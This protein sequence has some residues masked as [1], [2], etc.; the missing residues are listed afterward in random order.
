MISAVT[1]PTAIPF[2]TYNG[3][4]VSNQFEPDK[5]ESFV[6]LQDQK[7]FDDVFGEAAADEDAKAAMLPHRLPADVFGSK[8]V[9]AAIKRAGAA[10]EFKVSDVSVDGGVLIVRYTTSTSAKQR[11]GSFPEIASML[12]VSVPKADYAA[13]EFVAGQ[14]RVKKIEMKGAATQ[15]GVK[16]SEAVRVNGLDFQI[17]APMIWIIPAEKQATAIPLALKVTNHTEKDVR[18]SLMDT[19]DINLKDAAGNYVGRSGAR[20]DTKSPAPLLI[21][22]G[23]SASVTENAK[24]VH[25]GG[26]PGTV[27]L[28]YQD[29]TGTVWYYDDLRP[30]K[31]TLSASYANE[32]L[33]KDAGP[34]LWVGKA[35]TK[36]LAIEISDRVPATASAAPPTPDKARAAALDTL[37]DSLQQAIPAGWTVTRKDGTFQ[38]QQW[39]GAGEGTEFVIT[40]APPV[41]GGMSS[42]LFLWL[43]APGYR[44]H[45]HDYG[46]KPEDMPQGRAARFLMTWHG[47]M[48]ILS[49]GFDTL[50]NQP[51]PPVIK[52]VEHAVAAPPPATA[53]APAGTF[54]ST[55]KLW[56]WTYFAD[57]PRG[58]TP[59]TKAI[60]VS[61]AD[62][63]VIPLDD[64][65]DMA[66]LAA[67]VNR[68]HI[69][70]LQLRAATDK[71]L[72]ALRNLKD[73]QALNLWGTHV[74]DAGLESLKDLTGLK[75]LNLGATK[76]TDAGL[77]KVQDV[78]GLQTLELC[79]T[80]VTDAGLVHLKEL[81]ALQTLN[82]SETP[83]T[84]AGLASLKLLTG[85]RDLDL[86]AAP[87][88]DEGLAGLKELKTLQT[89]NLR[90][91]GVTDAGLV[92]L[93][94]LTG[95]K[96]LDLAATKVT[97][98]G[99][100]HL[101]KLQG[102]QELDLN[103]TRVTDAGL[104]ELTEL[105]GLQKLYL[106]GT[107]ITDAGLV[108]LKEL[109]D[110]HSLDF[111]HTQVTDAAVAELRKSL[112]NC[113]IFRD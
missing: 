46:T 36:E 86:Q 7:A 81:K 104:A 2:D 61:G 30:G 49:D 5:A 78:K 15:P 60:T 72:L 47:G 45:V 31:Y 83:V 54:N 76:V 22:K 50:G 53:T 101:K 84:G 77:A 62:W 24:L 17:V 98:A 99:L 91:T 13:V 85:L 32:G 28:T 75:M 51:W 9:V 14:E 27:S 92:N 39:D 106:V 21:G 100:A 11:V 74:T 96:N 103:F 18:L 73:L 108:H 109:K 82:L 87:V 111:G 1:K 112:P 89:L 65:L 64:P 20:D 34:P 88:T 63:Y 10:W 40:R 55:M 97:G 38:P 80:H 57:C 26:K 4:F 44:G 94:E 23:Q 35:T 59:A 102:L 69:P 19:I 79:R 70:G 29:D 58:V 48:A 37:K 107:A 95:L 110:L 3:Y 56:V 16:E 42:S 41:K 12:I 43:M 67:E 8:I 105:K 6:V 93:K 66:A 71:D 113:F 90:E 25:A 52:A 33:D 68:Q